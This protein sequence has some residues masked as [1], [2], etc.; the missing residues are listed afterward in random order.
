MHF[1][2]ELAYTH[3]HICNAKMSWI[4][5]TAIK[6]GMPQCSDGREIL[7]GFFYMICTICSLLTMYGLESREKLSKPLV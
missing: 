5:E 2:Q 3:I 6:R 7:W 1:T 4:Y